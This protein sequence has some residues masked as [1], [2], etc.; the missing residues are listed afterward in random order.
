VVERAVKRER[1]KRSTIVMA[2]PPPAEIDP[3]SGPRGR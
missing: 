1:S 3:G 2:V